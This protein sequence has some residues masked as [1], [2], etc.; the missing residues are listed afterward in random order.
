MA[1]T[2]LLGPDGRVLFA[3]HELACPATGKVVLA[4]RFADW[5]IE[6]RLMFA[7]PMVV[8]SCCRSAAHNRAIGGHRRSLH[9]YDEPYHP[10]GGTAA[11]DIAISDGVYAWML[12][13]T[14][15]AL[16]WSVGISARAFMHLD[17]RSRYTDLPP[18]HFAYPN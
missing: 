11:I 15:M 7:S 10:T 5:L 16:G 1:Q 6:L 18:A 9:V 4:P 8:T 2:S 17:R 13:K 14:A 12:A 3:H